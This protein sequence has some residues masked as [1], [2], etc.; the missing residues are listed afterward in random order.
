MLGFLVALQPH[1]SCMCVVFR[2]SSPSGLLFQSTKQKWN[3]NCFCL[4]SQ[5]YSFDYR[6]VTSPP[7]LIGREHKSHIL[8]GG[9]S[10]SQRGW[11]YCLRPYSVLDT[12]QNAFH[13]LF[14][15][16]WQSVRCTVLS[17]PFLKSKLKSG[18][19]VTC[20][21]LHSKCTVGLQTHA[22]WLQGP[23]S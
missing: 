23:C 18:K 21:V 5:A 22:V 11:R 17:S 13:Q 12:V 3:Q 10:R 16:S 14:W 2:A 4:G 8:V 15:S 20:L 9:G 19:W 1:G 7:R 6:W